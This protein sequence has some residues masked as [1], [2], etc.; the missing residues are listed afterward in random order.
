MPPDATRN[1]SLAGAML[2]AV[3]ASACCIG[4]LAFAMLGLSG[5]GFLVAMEPYRPL[6]TVVTLGLL[7]VGFYTT[8]RPSPATLDDCKCELPTTKRLGHW[9]LWGASCVALLALVSPS[10]IPYLL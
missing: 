6:F 2:S 8:Y 7:G 10:L 4:P 9:M 5:A 1:A 3:A